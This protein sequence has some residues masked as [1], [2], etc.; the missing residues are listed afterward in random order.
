MA[1]RIHTYVSFEILK[2]ETKRIFKCDFDWCDGKSKCV[3]SSNKKI[4]NNHSNNAVIYINIYVYVLESKCLYDETVHL[5]KK[6]RF[7]K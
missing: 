1:G 6:I 7:L 4:S 2:I 3:I 5:W